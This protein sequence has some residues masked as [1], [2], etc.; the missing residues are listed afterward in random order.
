MMGGWPCPVCGDIDEDIGDDCNTVTLYMD[1][2]ELL[3]PIPPIL[4]NPNDYWSREGPREETEEAEEREE[5]ASRRY[6]GKRTRRKR[7]KRK[8]RKTRR[9]KKTKRRRKKRTRRKKG[10][11]TT[12]LGFPIPI[13]DLWQTKVKVNNT[14]KEVEQWKNFIEKKT[15]GGRRK[16]RT[17][18]R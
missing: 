10:G 16:K 11:K 6:G 4:E 3:V 14:K 8:K 5:R 7:R 12:V 13:F 15:K 9:R 17:R 2:P 1:D 18:R